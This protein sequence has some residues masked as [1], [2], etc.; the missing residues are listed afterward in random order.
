MIWKKSSC[1]YFQIPVKVDAVIFDIGVYMNPRQDPFVSVSIGI[2]L[3]MIV[4]R[5][6]N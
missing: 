1:Y 6:I 5:C 4:Q 3:S 2:R